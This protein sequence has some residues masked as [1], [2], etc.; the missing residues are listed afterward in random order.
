MNPKSGQLL[1]QVSKFQITVDYKPTKN[2]N[3]KKKIVA[4]GEI[5]AI[6][7]YFGK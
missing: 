1:V 4:V 6:I 3:L 5:V 2:E 7:N